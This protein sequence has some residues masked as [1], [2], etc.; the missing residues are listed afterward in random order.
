[1]NRSRYRTNRDKLGRHGHADL[2]D[3]RRPKPALPRQGHRPI[4]AIHLE[5][6]QRAAT[7][8]RVDVWQG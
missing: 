8:D 1:M 6:R 5:L 2:S 3:F 4:R 7:P